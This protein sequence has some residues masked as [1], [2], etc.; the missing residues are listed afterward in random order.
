MR[1]ERETHTQFNDV[2]TDNSNCQILALDDIEQSADAPSGSA[3][4]LV[5]SRGI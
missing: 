4:L 1:H 5:K 2:F 3:P